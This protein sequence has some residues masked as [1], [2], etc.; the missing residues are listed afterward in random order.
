M[1]P[2]T[3]RLYVVSDPDL[4]GQRSVEEVCRLALAAGAGVFLG[5]KYDHQETQEQQ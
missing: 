5:R 2:R 4:V 3:L 1:D